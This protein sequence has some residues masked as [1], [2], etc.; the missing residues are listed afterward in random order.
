MEIQQR[1]AFEH[2]AGLCGRTLPV[3][4]DGRIPEDDIYVGR[5][6][7]DAPDI[8]GFVYVRAAAE[9]M[10]GDIIQVSITDAEGYDLIGDEIDEFTE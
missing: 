7:W 8:D 1:V 9:H 5:T 3:M 4:I 2:Q 10:S 6:T